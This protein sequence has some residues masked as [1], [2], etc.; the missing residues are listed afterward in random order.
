MVG[1]MRQNQVY[2]PKNIILL[3]GAFLIF[4]L[5]LYG[6]ASYLHQAQKVTDEIE[7]IRVQNLALEAEIEEKKEKIEYLKTP[8]R[9]EKEAKTQMG[10]KR[11]GE[12]VMVFVEEKIDLIP[13]QPLNQKTVNRKEVPIIE[14]WIWVFLGSGT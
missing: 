6:I 2:S 4:F 9:I 7:K 11:P 10:K 13:A 8:Q 1:L 3:V 5:L 12:Q 14:K